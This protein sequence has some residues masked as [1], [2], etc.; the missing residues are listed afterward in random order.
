MQ[1][2][3]EK[4]KKQRL[5]CFLTDGRVAG[6]N[7]RAAVA[8][9]QQELILAV[10]RQLLEEGERVKLVADDHRIVPATRKTAVNP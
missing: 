7:V 8:R 9:L 1:L 4:K 10:E 2:C 6:G 3:R 5:R